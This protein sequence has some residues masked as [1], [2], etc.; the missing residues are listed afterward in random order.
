MARQRKEQ[1]WHTWLLVCISFISI[2]DSTLSNVQ[3]DVEKYMVRIRQTDLRSAISEI[4]TADTTPFIPT[5][6]PRE[7]TLKVTGVTE[8][9]L[10]SKSV[11]VVTPSETSGE[12]IKKRIYR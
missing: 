5:Y 6:L 9:N 2:I 4:A 1:A 7:M 12:K 10:P 11:V 8:H 3:E